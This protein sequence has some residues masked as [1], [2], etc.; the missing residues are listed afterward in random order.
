MRLYFLK[1]FKFLAF[2]LSL[3]RVATVPLDNKLAESTLVVD[4][5]DCID[6]TPL[7]SLQFVLF[8]PK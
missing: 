1:L 3:S 2:N 7:I 5:L 4:E 6:V 8:M